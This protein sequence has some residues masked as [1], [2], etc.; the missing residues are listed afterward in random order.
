MAKVVVFGG[1]RPGIGQAVANRYG[2]EGYEVHATFDPDYKAEAAEYIEGHSGVIWTEL[3]HSNSDALLGYLSQIDDCD[4]AVVAEFDFYMEA[5]GDFDQS[6]WARSIAINLTLPKTVGYVANNNWP[7]CKAVAYV[8]STEGGVGSFGAHA[9]AATKAAVHNLV[10]SLANTSGKVRH[11]AAAAGWVGGVMDTDEVFNKS[12]AITP[13]G[14]LGSPDEIAA[15]VRFLN[16]G[17]ASFVNGAVLTIDGGYSG[18]DT[19]SKYEFQSE[20]PPA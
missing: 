4:E 13:L 16:S 17:E 6:K 11:N 20:F 8:T 1:G 5:Q 18:V 15:A 19:I 9:Y 7:S 2:A 14:R 3:D 12:R 10:K